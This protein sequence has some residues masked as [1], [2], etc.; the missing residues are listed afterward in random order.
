MKLIH[1]IH[2]SQFGHLP[3]ITHGLLTCLHKAF[4]MQLPSKPIQTMSNS[5]ETNSHKFHMPKA[6][7]LCHPLVQNMVT[8]KYDPYTS[9][10]T[11]F[12]FTR[13][14]GLIPIQIKSNAQE[15][16]ARTLYIPNEVHPYIK[17]PQRS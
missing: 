10:F 4:I 13:Q 17:S 15:T 9:H 14:P 6:S 12:A 7:H 11:I 2:S 16:T 5:H 1:A 8:S 3:K